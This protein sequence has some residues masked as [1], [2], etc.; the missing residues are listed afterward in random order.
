MLIS[1]ESLRFYN[2]K[3]ELIMNEGKTIFVTGGIISMIFGIISALCWI[4]Q[5]TTIGGFSIPIY[6]NSTW[7]FVFLFLSI[8][9]MIGTILIGLPFLKESK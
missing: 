4:P 6:S 3:G 9:V 1:R 5:Q 2:K 7:S 8:A